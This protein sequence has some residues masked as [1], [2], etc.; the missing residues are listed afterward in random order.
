MVV[1]CVLLM[2]SLWAQEVGRSGAMAFRNTLTQVLFAW[3]LGFAPT[4]RAL[5]LWHFCAP[6]LLISYRFSP[7]TAHIYARAEAEAA[8]GATPSKKRQ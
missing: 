7:F 5:A 4:R 6:P 8:A 3:P 2:S 1:P